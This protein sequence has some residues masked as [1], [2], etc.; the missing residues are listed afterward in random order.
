MKVKL[1]PAYTYDHYLKRQ[2]EVERDRRGVK[3]EQP[4]DSIILVG[5]KRT[6]TENTEVV[7]SSIKKEKTVP[8]EHGS[9][10]TDESTPE[11]ISR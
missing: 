4:G 8:R 7:L 6:M 3:K 11:K 10:H 5:V 2:H 1:S 9:Y